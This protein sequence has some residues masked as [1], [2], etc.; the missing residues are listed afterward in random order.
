MW[1]H[2]KLDTHQ[3][4]PNKH[5]KYVTMAPGGGFDNFHQLVISNAI[6]TPK[7][8]LK[9]KD[10]NNLNCVVNLIF[11]YWSCS[12]TTQILLS[13]KQREGFNK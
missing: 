7:K 12:K 4:G 11:L 6:I 5:K 9:M 10:P 3:Y 2:M 8:L 1:P 13:Y